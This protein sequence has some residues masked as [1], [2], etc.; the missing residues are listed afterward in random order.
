[1]KFKFIDQHKKHHRVQTLCPLL[2]VTA[3]GYYQWKNR[4]PSK[5][6]LENDFVLEKIK[7]IYEKNK[8]VY[9][10]PRITQVLNMQ[11]IS[12][13]QPRVARL[14][15]ANG[16]V[17]KTQKKFKATTNS[18]HTLPV[19]ADLVG[20]AFGVDGPNKLWVGDITYIDT[21]EGW[22]YLAKVM[23][24]Y[25]REIIG[26]AVDKRMTKDLVITAMERSIRKRRPT[27]SPIF[28]SDRGSQYA[29]YAFRRL[30][31]NNQ[32]RQSMSGKGNCYDNAMAES[33]FKTLKTELIYQNKYQTRQEAKQDIFEYIEVFYNRQRLHSALGYKTPVEYGELT[34]VA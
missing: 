26:W 7:D 1:M 24:A 23:D 14:M 6:E 20:Q 19:S 31:V 2:G 15:R 22:L 10:S 27:Q 9:G 21:D 32:I 30:L 34:N 4:G 17:A 3:S 33:F 25:N 12:C 11:S 16:I 8:G 13:S 18:N 5:R 28:H 29:S